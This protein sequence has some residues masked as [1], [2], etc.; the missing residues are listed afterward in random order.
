M[1]WRRQAHRKVLPS[2]GA[3][4]VVRWPT[5]RAR[6]KAEAGDSPLLRQ[7]AE[8]EERDRWINFLAV[9]GAC[10]LVSTSRVRGVGTQPSGRQG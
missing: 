4:P 1:C 5:R 9:R 8:D 2:K 10:P 7:K 3:A 6:L